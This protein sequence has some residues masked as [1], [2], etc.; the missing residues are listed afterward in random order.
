MIQQVFVDL[1]GVL[2]DFDTH[3]ERMFG[4]RPSKAADNADWSLV[5]AKPGFY[6][7]MPL[8]ADARKLWSFVSNLEKKPIILTGYPKSLPAAV[9][10][11]R[12]MVTQN[13]G[14]DTMMIACHSAQKCMYAKPGDILIDDWDKYQDRWLAVGGQWISHTSAENSI[15]QLLD[16]GVGF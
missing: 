2:A 5:A 15:Q 14:A 10:D 3:Y 11:K 6:A 13:F 9:A 7:T 12:A 4:V 8:M 16:L 1:D